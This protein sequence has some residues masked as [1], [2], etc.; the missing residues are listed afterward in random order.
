MS[1]A[2]NYA[3]AAEYQH[4]P[5]PRPAKSQT[6]T[7]YVKALCHRNP[8]LMT[9]NSFLHYPKP[10]VDGCR[11]AALDFRKGN[12]KPVVRHVA[13]VDCLWGELHGKAEYELH[14]PTE[15]WSRPLQGRVLVLEDLTVGAIEV[16]GS[17]LDLDP[18][19]FAMHLHTLHRTGS[20]HQIPDEATLPSRLRSKNYINISYQRPVFCEGREA[21]GGKWVRDAAVDRKLVLLRSTTIALA[22]HVLSIIVV[23]RNDIW[24]ALVLVDPPLGGV[25]FQYGHKDSEE[26]RVRLD[27]QPFLGLYEDFTDPPKFSEDW[28]RVLNTSRRS[29]LE[30]IIGYWERNTPACFSPEEPSLEAIAYYPLRIVAAE[31][32][33]YV[34]VMQHCIKLYQ[35]SDTQIP[36]LDRINH[37]LRELQ[38]WRLRSLNSQHKVQTVIRKLKVPQE[39]TL[40]P[41]T[42]QVME[43]IIEDFEVILSNMQAAGTR[44]ENMLPVV[45]SFI[46]IIDARRSFAETA[47]I[48]RLTI[49]ALV[50]IPLSYVSSLFSMNPS[51]MPGSQHFWVYFAVAIPVTLLVIIMARPPTAAV[52]SVVAWVRDQGK[53]KKPHGVEA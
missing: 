33:K 25:H 15:D 37:D 22:A 39:A 2:S 6:Y 24:I 43:P 17:E 13:D 9:L 44:L 45:T 47:N 20:K 30:D 19:F 11:I 14:S 35:Y 32:V 26:H 1:S 16:L 48:S 23:Q 10:R 28:S 21:S 46:Q 4:L 7:A 29:L 36:T 38:G 8:S 3:P 42:H 52:R 18:L 41:R 53:R 49:L 40:H 50:F 5:V 34:E 27:I 12:P 51:N 31:W